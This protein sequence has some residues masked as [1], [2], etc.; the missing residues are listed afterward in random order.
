MTS[1]QTRA[2]TTRSATEASHTPGGATPDF[3]RERIVRAAGKLFSEQGYAATSVKQ[4]ATAVQVSAPALYWHFESKGDLLHA[5]IHSTLTRFLAAATEAISGAGDD[6]RD[7]LA[8]LVRM[9]VSTQINEVDD[10]TAYSSLYAPGHL[11]KNL[12]PAAHDE[13]KA[14]EIEVFNTIREPIRA[15]IASGV[16]D[17]PSATV[18]THAIVGIIENLPGW[19]GQLSTP[20]DERLIETHWRI[21]ERIVGARP[22][23]A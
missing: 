16:F 19:A 4:I 5:V 23:G 2:N 13:L 8:A 12:S 6:P 1:T 7:Q 18:A 3:T 9:Y 17:T 20:D 22:A 11:F 10:V 15:G 14:L 21:V